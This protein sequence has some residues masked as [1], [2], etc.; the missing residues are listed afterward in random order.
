[1]SAQKLFFSSHTP[2]RNFRGVMW[3]LFCVLLAHSFDSCAAHLGGP[4]ILGDPTVRS[5]AATS[6]SKAPC[7]AGTS[8]SCQS[9][10]RSSHLPLDGCDLLSESAVLTA[11]QHQIEH[12]T[13]LLAA[14]VAVI[15]AMPQVIALAGCLYGRA[16]PPE[17]PP[18]SVVLR[19]S[20]SSR[21]PPLSV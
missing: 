21:A 5:L 12:P 2:R 4:G 16:G 8:G 6:Q 10:T 15:P 18:R 7:P 17:T 1:M 19:S 3:L 11:S 14:T 13:V 20:L 9:C